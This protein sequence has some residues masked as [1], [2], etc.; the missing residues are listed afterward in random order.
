[1]KIRVL[2][3]LLVVLL[4][5][6]FLPAVFRSAVLLFDLLLGWVLFLKRVLPQITVNWSAIAMAI[7]CTGLIVLGSQYF[8]SWFYRSVQK[9]KVDTTKIRPWLW[10]WTLSFLLVLCLPFF[11]GMSVIGIVHQAGWMA[12]TKEPVWVE[13]RY[14][15]A[16]AYQA[17][18]ALK[19]AEVDFEPNEPFSCEKLRKAFHDY[20]PRGL[21]DKLQ[22][23]LV[24]DERGLQSDLII[25]A[26]DPAERAKHQFLFSTSEKGHEFLPPEQLPQLLTK[27]AGRLMAL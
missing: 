4:V 6:V 17:E 27:Y 13:R 24:M 10:R 2:I 25:L 20:L 21:N 15:F 8:L 12:A 23:L 14:W 9:A 1:M 16:M 3:L 19:T 18:L 11:V 5:L 26:R 22:I 7:L